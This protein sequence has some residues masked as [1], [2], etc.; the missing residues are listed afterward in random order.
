MFVDESGEASMKGEDVNYNVF[1]LCG[2]LFSEKSYEEFKIKFNDLKTKFF[3]DTKVILHSSKIRKQAGV[4]KILIDE[5]TRRAFFEDLNK[6]IL[7]SNFQI[8]SCIIDK[9]RYKL[10][11][12]LRDT[13]Y[14]ESLKFMCERSVFC[15]RKE[16][17]VSKLIVCLEKRGSQ[18]SIIRNYYTKFI[19][20]GTGQ[21]SSFEMR[22]CAKKLEFRDKK[23]NINGLQLADLIAYPIGKQHLDPV[24]GHQSFEVFKCKFYKSNTGDINRF[25]LKKFPP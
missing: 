6:I 9:P 10:K 12:P 19:S 16:D 13:A 3:N 8:I 17:S 5:D 20:D 22:K 18:D 7:S 14:E 4:F 24:K 11:Y 23:D 1:V 21:M 2:V 15:L 25:G